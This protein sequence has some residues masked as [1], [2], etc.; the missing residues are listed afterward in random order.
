MLNLEACD[1]CKCLVEVWVNGIY[2]L[3]CWLTSRPIEGGVPH[4][5]LESEYTGSVNA[6]GDSFT[7]VKFPN[8]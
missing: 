6:P 1:T 4:C 7:G 5:E 2:E 3:H 8:V